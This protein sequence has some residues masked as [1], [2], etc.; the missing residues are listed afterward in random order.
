M[1]HENNSQ[2]LAISGSLDMPLRHCF[3]QTIHSVYW[4]RSFGD[5]DR[6]HLSILTSD[7]MFEETDVKRISKLEPE[8][9]FLNIVVNART[10]I[11]WKVELKIIFDT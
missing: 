4:L 11:A 10:K 5:G 2:T 3:H 6:G 8:S 1:L 7:L 9:G